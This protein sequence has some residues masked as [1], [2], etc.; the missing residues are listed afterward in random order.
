[1]LDWR[2]KIGSAAAIAIASDYDRFLAQ[3]ATSGQVMPPGKAGQPG[4]SAL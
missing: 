1:M 2:P 4:V 3:R